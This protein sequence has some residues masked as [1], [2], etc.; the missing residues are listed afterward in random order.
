ME[1]FASLT[2]LGASL[3]LQSN[4]AVY[5]LVCGVPKGAKRGPQTAVVRAISRG[6]YE[7]SP[8]RRTPCIR[9]TL[10][11]DSILFVT[12]SELHNTFLTV[13]ATQPPFTK[14]VLKSIT[15]E[16]GA[17]LGDFLETQSLLYG[18]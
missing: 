4:T 18:A 12:T 9:N 16:W 3:S 14:L 7:E 6:V 1:S 10:E 11:E 5:R 17:V 2:R 13:P 8:L 15:V